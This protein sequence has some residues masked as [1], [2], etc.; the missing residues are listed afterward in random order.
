MIIKKKSIKSKH[1]FARV[2]IKKTEKDGEYYDIVFGLKGQKNREMH[3]H[4][5]LKVVAEKGLIG[6]GVFFVVPRKVTSSHRQETFNAK[7]GE[8]ISKEETIFNDSRGAI[9]AELHY[10]TIYNEKE[11]KAFLTKFEII[12]I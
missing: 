4:Y 5:G 3:A 6:G 9:S 10:A 2:K 7:T 8:I 11:K 12:E 1:F